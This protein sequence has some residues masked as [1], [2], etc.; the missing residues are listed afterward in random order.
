MGSGESEN[1]RIRELKDFDSTKLGVKGLVD[2]G[3]QSVPN[4]FIR[5]PE[6]LSQELNCKRHPSSGFQIP[7]IDL[8]SGRREEIVSQILGTSSEWGFFQVVNHGIPAGLLDGVME[9]TRLFHEGDGETKKELYSRD[10]RK[11]VNF[12]SNYDLYKSRAANWRDTLTVNNLFDGHLDP[13]DIPS[14]CRDVALEY[15]RHMKKLGDMLLELLSLALGLNPNYLKLKTE[16]TRGWSLV[17]HYYPACPGPELTLGASS[18]SD[19]SFFTLLLQDQIGGLQVLYQNQWVNVQPVPGALVVNIGDILQ[20]ISNG[21]LRSVDHRVLANCIGPRISV[22]LFFT[23][24]ISSAKFQ[25]N[26]VLVGIKFEEPKTVLEFCSGP[27]DGRLAD[28]CS[29]EETRRTKTNPVAEQVFAMLQREKNC[30]LQRKK[31]IITVIFKALILMAH[32]KSFSHDSKP[33]DEEEE[34]ELQFQMTE[35]KEKGEDT[36][37]MDRSIALTLEKNHRGISFALHLETPPTICLC[38]SFR[39]HTAKAEP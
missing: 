4:I 27:G 23:G 12:C 11:Q 21:K 22:A 14:I 28:H 30:K 16:C 26:W 17:C 19:P 37:A 25:N 6:E 5:P 33:Y 38:Q 3:I 8:E 20:M 1:E 34:Q 39:T 36:N 29:T 31:S 35:N 15:T 10:T 32:D 13:N 18:H 24:L 9:G 7:V 2:E